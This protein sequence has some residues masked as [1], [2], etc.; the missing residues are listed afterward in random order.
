MLAPTFNLSTWKAIRIQRSLTQIWSNNW[1]LFWVK[2]STLVS[3]KRGKVTF[4]N[5]DLSG[6]IDQWWNIWLV[7]VKSWFPSSALQD[8]QTKWS[9]SNQNS[10]QLLLSVPPPNWCYYP[11]ELVTSCLQ[12]PYNHALSQFP[13]PSPPHCRHIR[14][15]CTQDFLCF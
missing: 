12:A 13:S 7:C 4:K 11:Q 9:P 8:R 5:G 10:A 15:L 1:I 2:I 14:A 6:D 3:L